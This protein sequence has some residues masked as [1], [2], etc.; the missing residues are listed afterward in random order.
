MNQDK[1]EF[2][3]IRQAL[4]I[5]GMFQTLM[6]FCALYKYRTFKTELFGE[7]RNYFGIY[8][9]NLSVRYFL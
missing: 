7:I 9:N 8:I 3:R 4:C 5:Q 1:K 2:K 6:S